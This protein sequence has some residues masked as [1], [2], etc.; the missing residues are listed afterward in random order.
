MTIMERIEPEEIMMNANASSAAERLSVGEIELEVIRRGKGRPV[1][2]L[3]G[4]QHVDPQARFLDLLG[5][6]AEI[7]APSHPGFGHSARPDDFDTVYDL[8]H[9]YLDVLDTLPYDRI[10]LVGLSFGGWLAAEIAVKS[11]HRI[12]RL[13][14]VD[15]FGIKIS[16][17]ETPDIL[18][19][20]NTSPQQVQRRSWHDPEAMAP[21]YD[22]MSDEALVVRARN[23]EALCLYGWHPYMYNPQLK[24]WLRRITR[25]TLVLWGASDGIVSP[26]YGQAYSALIPGSRFELIERAGHH[27][28]IE[29]PEAFAGRV[30][31]FL[32]S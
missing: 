27:P 32:A 15:A 11:C 30:A 10:D 29:Q 28:E 20:F 19:V 13:V 9:L 2:I 16:D 24:R 31:T 14:L 4:M 26:A 7:I 17:R 22:A 5:E 23:W 8:V 3:H 18:D 12:D 21:D 1:L 6:R 25:P